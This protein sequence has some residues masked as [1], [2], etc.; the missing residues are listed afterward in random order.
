LSPETAT[1]RYRLS[2]KLTGSISDKLSSIFSIFLPSEPE[3]QSCISRWN[4][5][6]RP[7]F[8]Q[9]MPYLS[10]ISLPSNEFRKVPWKHRN[11]A[12]MGKFCSSAQNSTF[13]EKLWSLG[14]WLNIRRS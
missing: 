8:H 13:R 10:P 14:M 12:E 1:D 11:S 7:K 4:H 9:N 3:W 2:T 6:W 5:V